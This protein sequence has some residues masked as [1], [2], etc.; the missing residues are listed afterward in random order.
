MQ[1]NLWGETVQP[2]APKR[3]HNTTH[4]LKPPV[5][6]SAQ[7]CSYLGHTPK[8]WSLAG[9]TTCSACHGTLYC[10]ICHPL[11]LENAHVVYCGLHRKG[12]GNEQR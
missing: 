12:E 2:P 4:T 1:E 6:V 11:P 5:K 8:A 7:D 3:Q 10:P 9:T